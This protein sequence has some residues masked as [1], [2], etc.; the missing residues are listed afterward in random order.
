MV[1]VNALLGA[2]SGQVASVDADVSDRG[3]LTLEVGRHPPNHSEEHEQ[4]RMT[5]QRQ[6]GKQSLRRLD[7]V[8]DEAPLFIGTGTHYVNFFVG[9]PPQRVSV[10]V[11]TGSHYTA[12]PCNGCGG[13][14]T[15]TDTYYD[16]KKSS[17]SEEL[18][19]GR[20]R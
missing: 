11:D 1:V 10:I 7:G 12:F 18:K 4:R 6:N 15:H 16:Q 14:G 20:G 17:T 8:L 3:F 9:T 5:W 13:C 19:C 2:V